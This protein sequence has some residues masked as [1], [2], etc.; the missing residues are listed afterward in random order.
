VR[1]AAV[2]V[3]VLVIAGAW[4]WWSRSPDS[5]GCPRAL[6]R[7][8]PETVDEASALIA[9]CGPEEVRLRLQTASLPDVVSRRS[10]ESPP[11]A[12]LAQDSPLYRHLAALGFEYPDDMSFAVLSAAWHHARGLPFDA[13]ATGECL[14]A[15]NRKMRQWVESVPPGSSVPAPEFGCGTIEEIDKGRPLWPQE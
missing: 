7:S 14:R 3:A 9:S 13:K 2:G 15:W 12:W 5:A 1:R 10:A 11:A 6:A 8:M 4:I